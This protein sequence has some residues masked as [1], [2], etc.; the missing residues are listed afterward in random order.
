MSAN[1]KELY[2]RL[3]LMRKFWAHNG[4]DAIRQSNELHQRDVNRL[5]STYADPFTDYFLDLQK[6]SQAEQIAIRQIEKAFEVIRGMKNNPDFP[7]SMRNNEGIFDRMEKFL[8]GTLG[9]EINLQTPLAKT[10]EIKNGKMSL[11]F[12]NTHHK[13]FMK[14]IKKDVQGLKTWLENFYCK[15]YLQGD[16]S[17]QSKQDK[18]EKILSHIANTNPP[19]GT[20]IQDYMTQ[21]GKPTLAELIGQNRDSHNPKKVPWGLQ[22]IQESFGYTIQKVDIKPNP[23]QPEPRS[24]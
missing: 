18:A 8:K 10:P 3:D 23:R 2:R 20:S 17:N 6:N 7:Q 15:Q 16:S 19:A 5:L 1:S 11:F 21:F 4:L 24:R 14:G 13:E 12:R 22:K 9:Q